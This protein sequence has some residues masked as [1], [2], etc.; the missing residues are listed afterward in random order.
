MMSDMRLGELSDSKR[1]LLFATCFIALIATSFGFMVRVMLLDEVWK[2]MFDLTETEKGQIFGVG[3]WPFAI[4]IVLFSLV[5]DKIG[6]KI[7]LWFAVVCH[8]VQAVMLITAG[9]GFV[10]SETGRVISAYR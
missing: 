7:T 2:P 9:A 3:L 10:A 4:S 1:K 8:I 6:Y 5:I